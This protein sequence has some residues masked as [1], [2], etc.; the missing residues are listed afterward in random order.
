M[1]V[2]DKVIEA[3]SP[4][5]AL[6][7]SFARHKLQVLNGSGYGY[8]NYGANSNRKQQKGWFWHSRSPK[9]DMDDNHDELMQKCRD[10]YYGAPIATSALKTTRT[11]VVGS[12]LKARPNIDAEFLGLSEEE[13]ANWERNT[14]REWNLWADSTSCDLERLNNFY[15]LQQLVFLSWIMNG[16]V[17]A[18]L[19]F[20][21]RPN[22]PYDLRIQ[23]IEADRVC[24]PMSYTFDKDKVVEGVERNEQ[25]EIIA[26]HICNVRFWHSRSPK[27]DMDDNHDELMQKC[28]D[29]YYGAPIATSALKTTRTNV[30]GSGLKARPNIDAEFLGL[31]EEEA[32][33]WERNTIREWNLWADSTSCDLER[34]NNFYELQQLVFLSWIMNGD[35]FALL[36]FNKR[37]NMPYDLRIQLIEADRV[38]NPMSYTFDK[39]K[40]V[41]GVER[42]EQGEIIAYHICNVHPKGF[43]TK[44]KTWKKV[45][46]YGPKTGRRNV[47]HCMMQERIGQNRGVPLL[48]PVIEAIKQLGRYTD[49]ELMAAV[50]SGMFAVFIETPTPENKIGELGSESDEEDEINEMSL[51]PGAIL[52]LNEGER[53]NIANPGRPNTAFDGFVSS[54]CR[55]IGSAIEIPPE[56]LLKQFTNNY[57]ASRGALLEAWKTFRMYR[58]WL[59][60][61]FCSAIEIPPELLLKQFTNNYSAS[62]GA[63]LEAWKTFRMY[64]AWLSND[65][66]QPAYEEWLAEG[67][68]KGRIHAPG[69]FQNPLIRKAYS[70]CAWS[71]PSAGQLDP[72]KEAN[73]AKIRVEEGFS[74]RQQETI[75]MNGGDF[76]ENNRQRIREETVRRELPNLQKA[77]IIVKEE[78][79]E[80]EAD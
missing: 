67:V 57:S 33:N 8:G 28:R 31:S 27:E 26:Y 20:N 52:A 53:A 70:N 7:R 5:T 72:V 19:P 45:L 1:N 4:E 38:C 78:G 64:R 32:A 51:A 69:F 39:D 55:Q 14:I 74:T 35:V 6:K 43:Y 75:E 63:L 25:G 46:A 29:T 44:D 71:G 60:N 56:L 49:A 24:N 62:R 23:L 65:F 34:L 73:A 61:D 58:A 50:V 16:D 68:A 59:S 79:E 10:T 66:C 42:N 47:L 30:V 41:E 40:V 54:L 12:G 80:G 15:E 9:E 18:L 11:N 76:F 48:A 36:P 3:I 17:F 13:A 21:K 22:M 2:L 37:P 77:A